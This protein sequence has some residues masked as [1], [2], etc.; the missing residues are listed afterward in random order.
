MYNSAAM[1][2]G[3][4]DNYKYICWPFKHYNLKERLETFIAVALV[5]SDRLLEIPGS[6]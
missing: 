3:Y 2:Y 4:Y 5:G 6:K 1:V